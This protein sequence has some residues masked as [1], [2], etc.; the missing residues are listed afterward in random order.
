MDKHVQ[1]KCVLGFDTETRPSFRKGQ[2]NPPAIVQLSTMDACLVAQIFVADTYRVGT[3]QNKRT[4]STSPELR[5][6]AADVRLALTEA[7]RSSSILKA[8]VGIDDD[9]IDLWQCWGIEV[10]GRLELGGCGQR[11]SLARLLR[12]ATGVELAKPASVQKSDWAAPLGEKQVAYAAAD[13]WAGRAIY[14]RLVELDPGSFSCEPLATLLA[15]ER[16]CAHLFAMRTA[17]H[18]TKAAFAAAHTALVDDG[19]PHYRGGDDTENYALS[20]RA[21]RRLSEARSLVAKSLT[22]ANLATQ[23]PVA[24]VLESAEVEQC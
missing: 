19:L 6:R 11:W 5:C 2:L 9:A 13:A 22:S 24:S 17:R 18:A 20:K 8:G 3:R 1:P 21:G 4:I 23:L 12:A 10:N 14:E 7:L 15:G 16:G